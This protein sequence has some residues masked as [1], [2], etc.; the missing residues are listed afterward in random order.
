L[1]L[2]IRLA[3]A[4]NA[5]A[6]AQIRLKSIVSRVLDF[7]FRKSAPQNAMPLLD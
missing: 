6:E 4:R 5:Y 3:A 7:I 2:A 1:T